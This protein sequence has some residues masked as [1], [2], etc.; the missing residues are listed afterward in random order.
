MLGALEHSRTR[1][2]KGAR[3]SSCGV[4]CVGDEGVEDWGDLRMNARRLGAR[5]KPRMRCNL[6]RR[7]CAE[8]CVLQF[9]HNLVLARIRQRVRERYHNGVTAVARK[10][11][12]VI[13]EVEQRGRAL[14]RSIA[15]R[16]LRKFAHGMRKWLSSDWDARE[17]IGARLIADFNYTRESIGHEHTNARAAPLEKRIGSTC[18]RKTQFHRGKLRSEWRTGENVKAKSWRIDCMRILRKPKRHTRNAWR[19]ITRAITRAIE[20]AIECD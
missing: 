12:R 8:S 10:F 5:E 2:Q 17:E 15:Q 9:A 6:A 16:S 11:K 19:V 13:L 4:R 1:E 7:E 18:G 3:I 14:G 20:R